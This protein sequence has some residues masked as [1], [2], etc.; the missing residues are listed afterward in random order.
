M[1]DR[2]DGTISL[3]NW[4]ILI[5]LKIVYDPHHPPAVSVSIEYFVSFRMPYVFC[6]CLILLYFSG[7]QWFYVFVIIFLSFILEKKLL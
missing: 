2:S 4:G 7:F 6:S 3:F 1:K 5:F